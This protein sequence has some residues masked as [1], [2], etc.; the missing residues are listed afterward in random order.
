MEIIQTVV[1]EALVQ[2]HSSTQWHIFLVAVVQAIGLII[3]FGTIIALKHYL[4]KRRRENS[5]V[6]TEKSREPGG[7]DQRICHEIGESAPT[8][9]Y[10]SSNNM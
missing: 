3:I 10:L 9:Y 4:D 8:R 2:Y 5:V 6:I 7:R 1:I